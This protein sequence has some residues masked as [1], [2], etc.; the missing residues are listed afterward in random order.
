MSGLKQLRN[1]VRSIKSTQKIT[2]AM[3]VVSAA[4]LK[5]VKEKAE[6]LNDYARVLAGII[7]DLPHSDMLFSGQQNER[8]I[9]SKKMEDK[10]H[11]LVIMSSERGLCGAFNSSV[12][13][14]AKQSIAKLKQDGKELK[15][16]IVGQKGYDALKLQYQDLIIENYRVHNNEYE[17]VILQLKDKIINLIHNDE[18]GS[19]SIYYNLFENAI[20]QIPSELSVLPI[21]NSQDEAAINGDNG[22]DLAISS[23]EAKEEGQFAK[24]EYDGEDILPTVLDMYISGQI[25]YVLLQSKASEEGARMTAMDSASK[26]AG[27]LIDK[28]TLQLNRSRQ[29]MITTEL[30][31]IIAGAEAV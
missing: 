22:D 17:S 5:R 20:T 4:K 13:K 25:E 19:C 27:E 29:A 9:F 16:I 30:I 3:K 6:G 31:E 8:K 12:V 28:L 2:K 18:I 10:P 26:N 21:T 14:L 1:R 24:Y 7:N 15:I 23:K 11:L